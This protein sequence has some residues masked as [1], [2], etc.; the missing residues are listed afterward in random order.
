MIDLSPRAWAWLDERAWTRGRRRASREELR[1]LLPSVEPK[2]LDAVWW[3]EEQHGDFAC[4]LYGAGLE[5]GVARLRARGIEPRTVRHGSLVLVG[6][7]R[8]GELWIDA[9]GTLWQ[10]GADQDRGELA[11]S[12]FKY[13]ERLAAAP[14]RPAGAY[15]VQVS[16]QAQEIATTLGL[17]R[18]EAVSEPL[19]L[20]ATGGNVILEAALRGT[21]SRTR[22]ATLAI[23]GYTALTA[24]LRTL[25]SKIPGFRAN[26]APG[27]PSTVTKRIDRTLAPGL[28]TFEVALTQSPT[29]RIP[30]LDDGALFI[31]EDGR[32]ITMLS[33]DDDGELTTM[34]A[35]GPDHGLWTDYVLP[36]P[37]KL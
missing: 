34:L 14:E 23:T 37:S 6:V 17:T 21:P 12:L 30:T 19:Y 13:L 7:E 31:A 9:R 3:F 29:V 25:A 4:D 16:P 5:L 11:T 18:D 33:L 28:A 24:T 20:R 27:Q 26:L 35:L 32:M 10:S 15:V 8:G 22:S 2:L 36:W 1:Q